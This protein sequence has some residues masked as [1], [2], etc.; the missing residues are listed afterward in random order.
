LT[1]IAALA[2][3]IVGGASTAG[4]WA[5]AQL[6]PDGGTIPPPTTSAPSS[7][8]PAT[9]SDGAPEVV[10][11]HVPRRFRCLRDHPRQAQVTAGWS[12]PA[13][14]EVTIRLDGKTI[15]QG[16]DH[17]LT[18]AIIAGPPGA[19]GATVVFPCKSG[20]RHRL[21]FH[22]E[23]PDAPAASRVVTIRK[24]KAQ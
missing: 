11:F 18:F 21:A 17:P 20:G 19:L 16:L 7:A 12:V 5:P 15:A 24:A 9:T 3:I 14:T 13:A 8:P 23:M 10:Q 6:D 2:L 4:A 1:T 22:W